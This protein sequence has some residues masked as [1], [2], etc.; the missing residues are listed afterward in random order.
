[1]TK[2]NEFQGTT[3]FLIQKRLGAGGFGVVYQAYD[4]EHNSVVAI[5]T[6]LETDPEELYRFKKEFRAS[7]DISHPNLAA[8]YELFSEGECCF[9]TMELINGK[10]FLDY[11]KLKKES[12]L[13]S[14]PSTLS[15][16]ATLRPDLQG[17]V[18]L[19]NLAG[20]KEADSKNSRKAANSPKK[21]C[22]VDLPKL[23]RALKQVVRGLSALHQA[24]K[25]HRD[26][27][28]SNV[29]VTSEGRVAILDFGLVSELTP[30]GFNQTINEY[31]VGTPAY[32]SP[33]Q[34]TG[35]PISTA[36]DWYSVGVMLYEVLTGEFP[37]NGTPVEIM[38]EKQKHDA[39]PASDRVSGVPESL[40]TLT[41]DL[42]KRDPKQRAS[43]AEI[44]QVISLLEG[45]AATATK[46]LT[47]KLNRLNSSFIGREKE[48]MVLE[49]A[50][51]TVKAGQGVNLY[52]KGH[53]GMGKSTI[54][55]HFLEQL[56]A[57]EP[58]LLIFSGRCY[59][60]ESVPY[61]AF[62]N[63][64]DLLSKYLKTLSNLEVEALL[65]IDVLALAR[66]FP[67]LKQVD[68]IINSRRKILDI[69]DFREL[70]R[71]AFN[72]MR[73]LFVRLADK[74]DVV[75]FID[76]LQWGDLDSAALISEIFSPPDSPRVF[77]IGSY[78]SEEA[79][80]SLFLKSLFSFQ[81]F[82]DGVG[83]KEVVVERLSVE[84]AENLAKK[85]MGDKSQQKQIDAIVAEAGG[86]PFFIG[87]LVQYALTQSATLA[88]PNNVDMTIDKVV[89]AR[90]K[91][92]PTDGRHLLE[93]V[94]VSG[95]PL[96]RN[97]AKT[98][99]NIVADEHILVILRSN[100]LL[101]ST[102][103][104]DYEEI[105]TYHDRIRE[106]ILVTLPEE[107]QQNHHNKLALAL[108]SSEL[109]DPER[110]AKHFQEAGNTAKAYTYMLSAADKAAE[111]LAFD[112]AAHLYKLA[113]ELG[114]KTSEQKYLLSIKLGDVLANAGRGAESAK[115]YIVAAK[116]ESGLQKLELQR[117]A[118]EQLLITGHIDEGLGELNH[119]MKSMGLKL[120]KTTYSALLSLLLQ[121]AKLWLRGTNFTKRNPTQLTD[122]ELMHIDLSLSAVKGLSM[123]DNIRSADFQTYHLLVALKAGEPFR[124]ARA[125][126][127]EAGYWSSLGGWQRR[128]A[129]KFF[130]QAKALAIEIDNFY[131]IGLTNLLAGF[132]DFQV[133][134]WKE[135]LQKMEDAES[136]VR[137]Y[138]SGISWET[139]TAH[140]YTLITRNYLGEI[141][142]LTRRL[143]IALKEALDRGDIYC[144][145]YLRTS[146]QYI[147]NL[148]ADDVVKARQDLR[149]ASDKWSQQGFYLQHW[150]V[151]LAENQI[152]L[153][154]GEPDNAWRNINEKW[155]S[156]KNSLL[157]GVQIILIE[158]YFIRARSALAV[159][160]TG[161]NKSAMLAVAVRDAKRIEREKMSYGNAF[162][163]IIYAGIAAIDNQLDKAITLLALAEKEFETANMALFLAA[164]RR[165]RGQLLNSPEGKK[166]VD[167]AE[168]WMFNQLIK[169]PAKIADMLI[170][171]KWSIKL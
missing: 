158:T 146:V 5:K 1:M 95:Q 72:A 127:L 89:S 150:H 130:E 7:A 64:I 94:A 16:M 104:V 129:N 97:L 136:M 73:E 91:Q 14:L 126:I 148:A 36:S 84:D 22:Q 81:P 26:I 49:E 160:A 62:D 68:S 30:Q 37:F 41:M 170:P 108:E 144:E 149:Q 115:A 162:A 82:A 134:N 31:I 116:G 151:M 12:A 20:A 132:M 83:V 131:L 133:G 110:L 59:E 75:L 46:P 71:K 35:K 32:M 21:N 98:V 11:V 169:N 69:T 38:L 13:A 63:I 141:K 67:V 78:R 52:I 85:L 128:Y 171:G 18:T 123:V 111:T 105:D 58:E 124:V 142:E 101:R 168:N 100:H 9:F 114:E 48:L 40:L 34:C 109:I 88:Q 57:N 8:L 15:E 86:N 154:C 61:K 87:E 24:G 143:P 92:L 152:D 25:I 107:L 47:Q 93:V 66:V 53:S 113:L 161:K 28:P 76:D 147:F 117:K 112:R 2:Q 140:V 106:S 102:A 70:R 165:R 163:K 167:N 138:C 19:L 119:V 27:K 159:A 55:R 39:V 166:L 6:L 74:K 17:A 79:E 80:K 118:A 60:Q 77:L 90:I 155:P 44:F 10:D 54:A 50:W 139:N 120:A 42:L 56:A 157:M 103:S 96:P 33:E 125:L 99:A 4:R 122:K 164:T 43:G 121:R 145:I 45:K 65:P 3:R 135:S 156:V 23:F 153:Y 137:G 29:L 51:Q